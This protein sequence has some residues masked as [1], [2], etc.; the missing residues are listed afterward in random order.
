MSV[1]SR[2]HAVL[3]G[4]VLTVGSLLS[5]VGWAAAPAAVGHSPDRGE[6]LGIAQPIEILFDQPMDRAT[7]EH[8]FSLNPSHA[9]EFHWADD[10]TLRVLPVAEWTRATTYD[11]LI[12]TDA[13]SALGERLVD[14]L[15]VSVTT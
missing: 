6:E 12:A 2:R 4:L 11:V 3:I 10:R 5:T 14:P 7:V 13:A 15:A 9:T 8:A 1:S